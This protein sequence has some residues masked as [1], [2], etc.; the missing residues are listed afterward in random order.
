MLFRQLAR[1]GSVAVPWRSIRTT[2]VHI[3][4]LYCVCMYVTTAHALPSPSSTAKSTCVVTLGGSA[5][6]ASLVTQA[7]VLCVGDGPVPLIVHSTIMPFAS[8]FTGEAEQQL[9]CLLLCSLEVP[10]WHQ[11]GLVCTGV[12]LVQ[13]KNATALLAFRACDVTLINS[14]IRGVSSQ[15]GSVLG[16][17]NCTVSIIN[18]TIRDNTAGVAAVAVRG[19]PGASV[20]QCTFLNNSG[21]PVPIWSCGCRPAQSCYLC[22]ECVEEHVCLVLKNAS[23]HDVSTCFSCIH[24]VFAWSL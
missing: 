17:Q 1:F 18:S 8:S 5:S 10:K 9:K 11:P 22:V 12:Q 20:D 3:V 19:A 16:F 14:S 24:T 7:S 2:A 23:K 6:N 21:D 13:A 4:F 15:A